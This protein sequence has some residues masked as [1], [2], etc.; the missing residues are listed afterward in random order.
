MYEQYTKEYI[1]KRML[2]RI[3]ADIDKSEGSFTY[4]AVAP[5]AAELAQAYIEL[6]GILEK[7]FAQT[8]YGEWLEK[9]AE[10]YGV[11][12]KPGTCASGE[13]TFYGADGTAIPTGTLVQT[14]A[15]LQYLTAQPTEIMNGV[16]T[17]MVEAAA[18]GVAY[19]IAAKTVTQMPVQL[20]GITRLENL[21]PVT[22][23][24]NTET[25]RDFVQRLL[26]KVR[27]PATSG[28]I[29]HYRQWA[30]EVPGIGEA[31]V[32]PLWDGPGTVK[33]I[34][35]D[36]NRL[37]IDTKSELI[38][39][40]ADYIE[41]NRPVGAAVCVE[42]AEGLEI[43]VDAKIELSTEYTIESVTQE[44]RTKL[45]EYFKSITFSESHV[46]YL[47]IG[48]IILDTSGVK[49]CP[50]MTINGCM[51]DIVLTVC[52]CPVL[53]NITITQNLEQGV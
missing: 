20:A 9:R 47:Q 50:Y 7:A 35:V 29:H 41:E 3:S 40:V 14:D 18:E 2:D 1:E 33:V 27:K 51:N 24:T 52:Q 49:Q 34:V 17:V 21:Y 36:S 38:K 32:F 26:F 44:F 6:D 4:D 15:G 46:S 22:G 30:L 31:K 53:N 37:P 13:V 19:N 28:N 8:S 45:Q 23:G 43:N 5:A 48:K 10:E 12:R 25:D 39:G 42:S 16:A 11:Y